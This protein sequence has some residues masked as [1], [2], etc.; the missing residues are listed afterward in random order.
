MILNL[1]LS[2]FAIGNAINAG[3][4]SGRHDYR[5]GS[6]WLNALMAVGAMFWLVAR[7]S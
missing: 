4:Y 7:L 1:I 5:F 2:F 6:Y 3:S